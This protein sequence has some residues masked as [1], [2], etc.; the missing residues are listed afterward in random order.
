MRIVR[1]PTTCFMM[2]TDCEIPPCAPANANYIP[3]N[4]ENCE[5]LE[6]AWRSHSCSQLVLLYF[7]ESLFPVS[8]MHIKAAFHLLLFSSFFVAAFP[9]L[10][11]FSVCGQNEVFDLCGACEPTCRDPNPVCV[12]PCL[13]ACRCRNGFIRNDEGRC[14]RNCQR[15]TTPPPYS[16]FNVRCPPGTHC[17]MVAQ[18]CFGRPCP[19]P[20]PACINDNPAPRP[21]LS[22]S[23]IR[24]PPG[25]HCEQVAQPCT[26]PPCMPPTPQCVANRDRNRQSGRCGENEVFD[27]CGPSCEPS[28]WDPNPQ[29]CPPGCVAGCRCRNGFFRLTASRCVRDCNKHLRPG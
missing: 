14:V 20:S 27:N 19:P 25:T 21:P 28:C 11:P 29:G 10:F 7:L 2:S 3:Y 23:D 18:P 26:R 13:P 9:Q 22:C 4:A 12:I 17:E 24:C 1:L 16:C 8:Y 5:E 6:K 15:P